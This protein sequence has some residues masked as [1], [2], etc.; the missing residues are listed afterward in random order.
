[1][2]LGER[3]WFEF[4]DK[5]QQLVLAAGMTTPPVDPRKL[6]EVAGVTRIVLSTA[7]EASGELFRDA[8]GL[9]IRL[10]ARELRAY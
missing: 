9:V 3:G 5:A 1:M 10:S 2:A 4:V 8:D 7:L 6:A